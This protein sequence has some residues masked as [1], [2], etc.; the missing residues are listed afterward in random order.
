MEDWVKA[1]A[2]IYCASVRSSTSKVVDKDREFFIFE[3]KKG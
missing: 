3:V 1:G 2:K